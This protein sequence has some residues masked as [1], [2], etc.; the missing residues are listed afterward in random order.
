MSDYKKQD[1]TPEQRMQEP[2]SIEFKK[3][4]TKL[5]T[6]KSLKRRLDVSQ[7]QAPSEDAETKPDAL[8]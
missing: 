1:Q 6:L 3:Q 8:S 2:S 5:I 7:S 4:L